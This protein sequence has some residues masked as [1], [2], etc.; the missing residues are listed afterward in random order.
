MLMA[1]VPFLGLVGTTVVAGAAP[2]GAPALA[3]AD[4]GTANWSE[5]GLGNHRAMVTV[6]DSAPVQAVTIPWRR[7]DRDAAAKAVLVYDP[8]GRAVGNVV[9]VA[10]NDESGSFIFEAQAGP[11]E[12]TFYYLPYQLLGMFG[13]E[14]YLPPAYHPDQTWLRQNELMDTARLPQRFAALPRAKVRQLQSRGPFH[15]FYPMEVCAT[16]AEVAA[17]KATLPGEWALFPEPREF[18]IRMTDALPYRWIAG[19]PANALTLTARPGE[20]LTFQVGVWAAKGGLEITGATGQLPGLGAP[21]C[22]NL[23][24][25]DAAGHDFTQTIP[26]PK[27]RVQSLWFGVQLPE[28]AGGTY[29]GAVKIL[30]GS[31]ASQD[32]RLTVKVAG[33]V[34]RDGGVSQPDGLSRLQWLNSRLGQ[35]PTVVPPYTP[36]ETAGDTIKIL[37]RQIQFGESGLPR[38]V[39]SNETAI[40]AAP[41]T[42][43][44][45][46]DELRGTTT[47]VTAHHAVAATRTT[48]G[49]LGGLAA[50][51]TSTTEFDG[52]VEFA[53][54][55]TAA[56][57]TPLPDLALE[58]P[59]RKEVATYWMGL[60][61][62]GGYRKKDLEWK[63]D[64]KRVTNM[65]WIGEV[66]AGMQVKLQD[67]RGDQWGLLDYQKTGLPPAWS[68]GGKGG[69][70]VTETGDTVLLRATCGERTLAAGESLTLKFR[71]LV[72]PF[73]PLSPDHWKHRVKDMTEGE[74]N[75]AHIHHGTSVA[76]FINYPFRG[77]ERL[78][79][80]LDFIRS[81]AKRTAPGTGAVE[82]R[83]RRGVNLYYNLGQLSNQATE[84]WALRSL[85]DSVFNESQDSFVYTD[86]GAVKVTAGGG[87]PWLQEHLG[88]GYVPGWREAQ[89]WN[90]E[91]G[92]FCAALMLKDPSRWNN[93]YVEGIRWLMRDTGID[94]LYLD[95][96]GFDRRTMQ[97]VARAMR[98]VTPDYR[99]NAHQGNSY[100]FLDQRNGSMNSNMEHLPYLTDL[101][102]GEMFDYNRSADYQLIE[103]SG[104]PFGVMNEMLENAGG[105]NAW[106][107]MVFGMNGRFLPGCDE[108]WKFW[109]TFGIE[110]AKIIGY[111]DKNCPVKPTNPRIKATVY[112]KPGEALI[113]LAEWPEDDTPA[114]RRNFKV[115]LVATEDGAMAQTSSF[116]G[117][118]G[119]GKVVPASQQTLVNAAALSE[120]LKIS[121]TCYQSEKPLAKYSARDENLW[122][123]DSLE[124]F[125]QPDPAAK[126]YFKFTGNANGAIFDA[127][128]G[129]SETTW[130]WQ[131]S[132]PPN[133]AWNGN[134][135]YQARQ[136]P[137]GWSGEIF[138][139]YAELGMKPPRPGDRI[140]FNICRGQQRPAPQL[141]G[142]SKPAVSFNNAG[143]FGL[144]TFTQPAEATHEGIVDVEKLYAPVATRLEI[145]WPALGLNPAECELYA[146]ALKSFQPAARFDCGAE[147]HIRPAEGALLWLRPRKT[148]P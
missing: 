135:N 137:D 72:T 64:I 52:A 120:G 31:A 53:I 4:Y 30:V 127:G 40:L 14:S 26:V 39:M 130:N 67:E 37:N 34:L 85:P 132:G 82:D 11:G 118:G 117:F 114:A 29:S 13:S 102:A 49:Q 143:G 140:G 141:S 41:M 86:Q 51:V 24:G 38:Q 42:L 139:A 148:A 57:A 19:G 22:F 123:D 71:L 134:W 81:T 12:Y 59:F 1:L 8:A 108:M 113:A 6:A 115:P 63:W 10:L 105:G 142:W 146:P 66:H 61:E 32:V 104:I 110:K 9:P 126:E 3:V 119:A 65:I 33:E 89:P 76:P 2:A 84:I 23:G 133:V 100:D 58:I 54:R 103:I 43:R 28:T 47:S 131:T 98:D 122:E 87:Y 75:I 27:G 121:F 95:G 128:P 7:R 35:E 124:I 97:R 50:R 18:P 136:T 145:D 90:G 94:G 107:G 101:W 16:A 138:I 74:A 15:S 20:Y 25:V 91:F 68:N 70:S 125:L 79:G 48:T 129:G 111:W 92:A 106:R 99:I 93:Y 147:L 21:T 55:L 5:S 88:G 46:R 144:I 112:Q 69:C 60:G 96:I 83:G 116:T 78:K 56:N 109:D 17:L 44:A 62:R 80:Y 45:G 73:K 77:T 36:V